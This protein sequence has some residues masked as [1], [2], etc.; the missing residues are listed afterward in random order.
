MARRHTKHKHRKIFVRHASPPGT[1]PGTLAADPDAAR[2]VIHVTA[3]GPGDF[4][5]QDVTDVRLLRQY[6]ETWPVTWINVDGLGDAK[7]IETL[8]EIFGLHRLALEDVLNVHQRPKVEEYENQVFI[9]G[10]MARFCEELEIEQ[11]SLFLAK[12]VVVTFQEGL[13]GDCFE[14]IRKHIREKVGRIRQ[15]GSDYLLYCLIDAIVDHYFPVLE[16]Y[17]ERLEKIEA[18]VV[19]KPTRSTIHRL[20]T[21]KRQLLDMRRII[22]PFRDALQAMLRDSAYLFTEDT[23]LYMRD[24]YDHLV[25]VVELSE[26]YRELAMSLT[27]VYLSSVSN[28]MNEIMKVLTV[29]ATIFMPL[30]FVAGLYGMN[31]NTEKSPFNMPELTWY[32]GYPF[33]LTIM[34]SIAGSML[35][36][37]YTRGWLTPST[38]VEDDAA[39]EITSATHQSEE[40]ARNSS[41]PSP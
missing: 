40:S 14:V 38:P 16:E 21:I 34:F 12:N 28:R 5:E 30:S 29:I 10:K 35:F 32:F 6:A 39:R 19:S 31:F 7:T 1:P 22:W 11:I 4:L 3:Y 17:A 36:V 26:I 25:Q 8:G 23:R 13:P 41:Q 15:M 9:I 20:H 2:P 37:F 27:D 18:E 24:C 33:A